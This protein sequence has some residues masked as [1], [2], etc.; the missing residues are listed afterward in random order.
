MSWYVGR[1]EQ[2]HTYKVEHEKTFQTCSGYKEFFLG[3]EVDIFYNTLVSKANSFCAYVCAF[4]LLFT[5]V[6]YFVS[7]FTYKFCT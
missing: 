6:L 7:F 1:S 2:I 5:H 3:F 4:L